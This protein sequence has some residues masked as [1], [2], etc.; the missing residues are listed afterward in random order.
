MLANLGQ[1]LWDLA[2]HWAAFITG[3]PIVAFLI[4]WERWRDKNI[5][6]RIYVAVFLIIGFAAAGFQTWQQER[7]ASTLAEQSLRHSRDAATAKQLQKYYAEASQFQREAAY[8]AV[9]GSEE[10]F[11]ALK[12]QVDAWGKETGAWILQNMG[13]A[14]YHRI[15][16]SE[17]LPNMNT[18]SSERTQLSW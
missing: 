12:K 4:F 15:I 10:E 13:D 8:V 7:S 2:G 16:Q 17:G 1:Y 5:P 6:F 14:A 11:N 18:V 9:N 3:G